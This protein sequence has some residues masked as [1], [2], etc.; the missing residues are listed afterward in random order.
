MP[1]IGADG[2]NS[3]GFSNYPKDW[4]EAFVKGTSIQN[5]RVTGGLMIVIDWKPDDTE[6]AKRNPGSIREWVMVNGVDTKGNP[7]STGK[8]FERLD[9]LD[10]RRD[11]T[12]CKKDGSKEHFVKRN[13]KYYCP[14]CNTESPLVNFDS[15]E[16]NTLSWNGI[17]ARIQVTIEK[18][19]NSDEERNRITR[20]EPL[21]K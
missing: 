4:Y 13:G 20:V 6:I 2:T 7:Y 14:H 11:Y 3:G 12:C 18:M 10:I 1:K 21:T 9:A 8:L 16:D 19:P 15:N 17:R 5:T